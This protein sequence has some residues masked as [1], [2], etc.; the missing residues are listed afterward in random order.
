M[1][2]QGTTTATTR[3]PAV[4]CVRV[5]RKR[6]KD[7]DVGTNT[8]RS[9]ARNDE[10][11]AFLASIRIGSLLRAPR[12][13]DVFNPSR[14]A[15]AG[16]PRPLGLI[17]DRGRAQET[18]LPPLFPSLAL[19]SVARENE[20]DY[21]YTYDL[22]KDDGGAAL[23]RHTERESYSRHAPSAADDGEYAD[24]LALVKMQEYVT[25]EVCVSQKFDAS[26]LRHRRT[27]TVPETGTKLLQNSHA[28]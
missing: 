5:T 12:P 26:Q 10:V 22:R 2:A 9:A 23:Y 3:L 4:D 1:A 13:G 20:N 27:K 8:E 15:P 25:R 21:D 16:G 14:H 11:T 7:G 19:T 18:F 6:D 28:T 24:T 17:P